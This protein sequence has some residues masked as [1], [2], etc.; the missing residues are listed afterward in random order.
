MATGK[1]PVEAATEGLQRHF[2][3]EAL[4]PFQVQAIE[5]WSQ[6]QDAIVTLSTGAGKSVCFQLPPLIDGRCTL[7][8]SPLVSLMQAGRSR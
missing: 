1:S 2:G 6:G 3:H 7:V 5:A 4:R 8:I